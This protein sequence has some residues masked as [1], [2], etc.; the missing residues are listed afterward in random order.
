MMTVMTLT[1]R[2]SL[3]GDL[4]VDVET[5]APIGAMTWFGIGGRADLLVRPRTVEA[6]A[7]LV[8]RCH[9]SNVALRVLGSGANLLVADEGVGGVVIKLDHP[10]FREV[11]FNPEGEINRM[12]AMAGAD[13]ARTLMD[14][15]RR[16]LAGLGQMA[17]IPASIGGAIRMNAG[18]AFGNISD[19]LESVTCMTRSGDIVTYPKSELRFEY[20]ATNI[21]DPIIL[22]AI[23]AVTPDDPIDLRDR[24][25]EIFAY[26][27]STQP[28]ADKSAGCVFKNPIDPVHGERV[29]AGKLIDEAGMKGK[30]VGGATVSPRHANFIVIDPSAT[31]RH[32]LDLIELVKKAV[33]DTAGIEL[34]TEIA[35]WQRGEDEAANL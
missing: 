21:P 33:F 3:F 31:A 2:S 13:M 35:I 24:V 23:F 7:M 25:K 22:S 18:G 34:E 20:R 11:R 12:K 30:A 32:V 5:D 28:L 15:T 8:K 4:D 26:K 29:S 17:G 14:T 16:G 6:L 10:A 9:R 1:S 19:S 27:K